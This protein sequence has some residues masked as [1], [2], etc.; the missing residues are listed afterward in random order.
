MAGDGAMHGRGACM[1]G[2]MHGG[3][4]GMRGRGVACRRDSH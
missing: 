2:G 4:G 1:V 3:E